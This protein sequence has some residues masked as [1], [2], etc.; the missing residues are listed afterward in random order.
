MI[1]KR[2]SLAVRHTIAREIRSSRE[3]AASAIGRASFYKERQPVNFTEGA[4]RGV[5]P[6]S[7]TSVSGR[8]WAIQSDEGGV[9]AAT[10]RLAGVCCSC[11]IGQTGSR[12]MTGHIGNDRAISPD[13]PSSSASSRADIRARVVP[14]D[15]SASR[16]TQKGQQR[17]AICAATGEE[18]VSRP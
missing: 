3:T 2:H 11:L 1:L 4:I 15:A 9:T 8:R 18:E 17:C 14:C 7:R 5:V 6:P 13:G 10:R 12:H 16:P